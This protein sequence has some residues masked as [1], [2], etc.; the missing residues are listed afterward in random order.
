MILQLIFTSMHSV[1]SWIWSNNDLAFSCIAWSSSLW[2]N[3]C[4]KCINVND[5][6]PLLWCVRRL[7]CSGADRMALSCWSELSGVVLTEWFWSSS[8]PEC[9]STTLITRVRVLFSPGLQN[10]INLVLL[11]LYTMRNPWCRLNPFLTPKSM[12]KQSNVIKPKQY[13]THYYYE[14]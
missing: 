8:E 4:S 14:L 5:L 9:Q 7:R 2:M 10:W 13:F 11:K 1:L 3:A 12:T 6:L